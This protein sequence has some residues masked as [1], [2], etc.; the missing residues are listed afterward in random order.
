M[1]ITKEKKVAIAEKLDNIKD[2]ATTIVFVNFTELSVD[3]ATAMREKLREQGVNYFV[4]KKTLIARALGDAFEGELPTLDGQ[5][6][7]A[8]GEDVIQPAQSIL[9]FSKEYQDKITIIGGVF[10]GAFK[11]KVEMTEIAAIPPMDVLRGMFV[12][13][14]NSPIQGLAIALDAIATKKEEA[15]A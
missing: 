13:V 7:V 8:Y 10:E 4:V 3:Q 5:V 6:A 12:N 2:N 11:D 14:I 15:S 9:A 1:A